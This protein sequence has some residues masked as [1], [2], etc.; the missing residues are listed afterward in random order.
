[1]KK[2]RAYKIIWLLLAFAASSGCN[3][4]NQK[5]LNRRVTLWRKDKIP[6]G[7]YYA[8]ENMPYI[9]PSA[10]ISINKTSPAKYEEFEQPGYTTADS[11]IKPKKAYIIISPQVVPNES[12]INA[13]LNFVGEGNYIF[14]SAFHIG[15]SL[16]NNLKV[17]TQV[18][19]GMF[20]PKDTLRVKVSN[21]VT[22]DALAF[23]YPGDSYSSYISSLDSQ[24]TTI[25]GT[26]ESGRADFVKFNYKSGG[27]IFLHFAPMAF[28]NFFLLHKNNKTYF[29]NVFS[30]LPQSI[31]EIKW[32]DYFRY[33]RNSNFSALNYILSNPSFRWAF[34]LLMLLFFFIYLFESKR[35]QRMIPAVSTL[36][37]SSLDFVKTIGQLYYQ[38]KDNLN[39]ANKMSVHFLSHVRTKYNLPTSFLNNEFVDK[40]SY[41]SGYNKNLVKES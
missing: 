17:K 33:P 15:D 19:N 34:W 14:I 30:Y 23:E 12:E 27:A 22:Y 5:K 13:M 28:T 25:L 26:D 37:N 18:A 35:K 31:T 29:D 39:L 6:Y 40:L 9:F 41:K 16:L 36:R 1:M 8:Y 3:F 2:I 7:T 32:D 20:F 38:K 4:G 11:V 10:N 24:Y 21:P